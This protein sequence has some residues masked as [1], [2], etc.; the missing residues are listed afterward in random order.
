MHSGYYVNGD[1]L[2]FLSNASRGEI[3]YDPCLCFF[4]GIIIWVKLQ[5]NLYL[6]VFNRRWQF[7]FGIVTQPLAGCLLSG[8]NSA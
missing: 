7:K 2:H 3:F 4:T 8:G 1:M 5:D 6:I